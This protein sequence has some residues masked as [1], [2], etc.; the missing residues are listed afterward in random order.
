MHFLTIDITYVYFVA[1]ANDLK[2]NLF[3]LIYIVV[4]IGKKEEQ[5]CLFHFWVATTTKIK[6]KNFGMSYLVISH[7][8]M[9]RKKQFEYE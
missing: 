3:V 2:P 4:T 8:L 7:Q 6:T 1:S 5:P 9:Q